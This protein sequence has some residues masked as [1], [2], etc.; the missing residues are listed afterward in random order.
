MADNAAAA[1]P[2]ALA[3]EPE[4]V[5]D[6]EEAALA[7]RRAKLKKALPGLGKRGGRPFGGMYLLIVV[8]CCCV[9]LVVCI[10]LV[11][12]LLTNKLTEN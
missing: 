5:I 4:P 1:S 10:Y 3:A 12:S 6:P 8:V 9:C 7:K 2:A 11:S